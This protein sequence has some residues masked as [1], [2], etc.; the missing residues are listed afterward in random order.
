MEMIKSE[1]QNNNQ[2]PIIIV[3][4]KKDLRNEDY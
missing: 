2:I 4:N 3:G 1:I